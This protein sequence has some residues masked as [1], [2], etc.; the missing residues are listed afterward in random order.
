VSATRKRN[1]AI[2][3]AQRAIGRAKNPPAVEKALLDLWYT[4]NEAGYEAAANDA[5][6]QRDAST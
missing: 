3:K 6:A 1:D 2:A 4:A 5:E